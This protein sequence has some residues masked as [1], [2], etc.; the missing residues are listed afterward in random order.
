[1]FGCGH[2]G[3]NLRLNRTRGLY[4]GFVALVRAGKNSLPELDVTRSQSCIVL[5]LQ[6]AVSEMLWRLFSGLFIC[7]SLVSMMVIGG[8]SIECTLISRV[9]RVGVLIYS[10][11]DSADDRYMLG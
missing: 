9:R 2:L 3:W 7:D 8:E 11:Q 1:M 5:L 6:A 10:S 4:C